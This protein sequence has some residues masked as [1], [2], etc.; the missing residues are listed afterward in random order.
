MIERSTIPRNGR[1]VLHER[2]YHGLLGDDGSFRLLAF[3]GKRVP[4]PPEQSEHLSVTGS[5]QKTAA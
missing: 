3:C 2:R 4:Q 1:T 5:K